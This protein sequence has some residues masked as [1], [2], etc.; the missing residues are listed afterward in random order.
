SGRLSRDR[1]RSEVFAMMAGPNFTSG[2]KGKP[3]PKSKMTASAAAEAEGIEAI[4]EDDTEMQGDEDQFDP[5]ARAEGD[6]PEAENDADPE[7]EEDEDAP[8]AS[9]SQI[10]AVVN[11]CAL[12]GVPDRA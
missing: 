12:H 9:A 10:M 11:M 5:E 2:K 6:E 1:Q 8:K 4:E 3:M 7:A